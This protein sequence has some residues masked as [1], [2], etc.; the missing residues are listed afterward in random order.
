MALP[1]E[2]GE[3]APQEPPAEEMVVAAPETQVQVC[4]YVCARVVCLYVGVAVV[5]VC[6][7]VCAC[8]CACACVREEVIALRSLRPRRWL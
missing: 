2:Q 7:Y 5:C 8:V 3:G 6:V 4:M 1:Q